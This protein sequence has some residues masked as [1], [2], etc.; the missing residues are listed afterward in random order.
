MEQ[1][2][3]Q[4]I[5]ELGDR[6]PRIRFLIRDNDKKYT[7]AFDRFFRSERIDVIPTP[8]RALNAN[9]FLE[10]W[11]RSVRAECLDKLLILNQAHL[12]RVMREYVEFFN[13]A[14]P[15]DRSPNPGAGALSQHSG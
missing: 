13:T 7:E 2:A 4:I 1:Q 3:R 14:R 5:W 8:V 12:R 6:E 15:P 9:A 10:R 11:I